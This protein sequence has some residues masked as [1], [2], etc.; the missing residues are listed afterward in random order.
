MFQTGRRPR[1]H[2]SA[3]STHLLRASV[4]RP[5]RRNVSTPINSDR[6]EWCP[7]SQ[8]LGISVNT[9]LRRFS[10]KA[11]SASSCALSGVMR[12]GSK[13]LRPRGDGRSRS[14]RRDHTVRR[15]RSERRHTIVAPRTLQVSPKTKRGHL[16]Q[17]RGA[18]QSSE[19]VAHQ[20]GGP[21]R[22]L[23]KR[24]RL[25]SDDAGDRLLPHRPGGV[26]QILTTR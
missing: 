16:V 19:S 15:S 12:P 14:S 8:A 2:S 11:L 6:R 3:I 1:S 9:S 21:A 13:L 25:Q 4:L 18:A 10:R 26:L 22:H 20:P 17:F 23:R 7:P 24:L 5:S